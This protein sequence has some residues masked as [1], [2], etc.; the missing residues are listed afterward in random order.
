[1][2]AVFLDRDGVINKTIFRMGK[3]RAPYTLEEF[4]FIEGVVEAVTAFKE[5]GFLVIVVTNQPDVS[6]GWVAMEQVVL[7]NDF[8]KKRLPIDEIKVCFHT[9]KENCSCRKP[10]PGMLLE[11][12]EKWKI[13]LTSSFMVGDRLSD[14]EAGQSAGCRSI[15]VGLSNDPDQKIFPDHRCRDL[16]EACTWILAKY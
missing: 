2:K 13:N 8:I 14:I 4:D 12:A 16:S 3:E 1:M 5:K 6:R 9:E 7:V 11:A 10:R 15:L